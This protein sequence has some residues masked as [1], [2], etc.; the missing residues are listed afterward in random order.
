M[1]SRIAPSQLPIETMP[2]S[3]PAVASMTARGTSFFAVSHF[4]QQPIEHDLVLGRILGVG[5]VL[6]VS[7]AAREVGA[8]SD[9]RPGSVR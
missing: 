2:I 9:G 1:A 3:L 5:A 7:R 8:P 4:S 6:G